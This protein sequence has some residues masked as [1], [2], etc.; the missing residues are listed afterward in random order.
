MR[1]LFLLLAFVSAGVAFST[2]N[3]GVMGLAMLLLVVFSFVAVLAFAQ[4]RIDARSQ[5][6][7]TVLGSKDVLL[8]RQKTLQKQTALSKAGQHGGIGDTGISNAG[9]VALGKA[10]VAELGAG[11]SAGGSG[12]SGDGGD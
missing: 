8:A 11:G 4:A 12:S 1:W 6:L 9:P 5:S 10:N 3:P 2:D 7:T